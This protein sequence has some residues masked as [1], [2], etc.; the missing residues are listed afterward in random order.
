MAD[1]IMPLRAPRPARQAQRKLQ[2]DGQL[3]RATASYSTPTPERRAKGEESWAVDERP[4]G[5]KT[6]RAL[7]AYQ[8][9]EKHFNDRERAAVLRFIQ[10]MELAGRIRIVSSRTYNGMPYNGPGSGSYL[11]SQAQQAAA[12]RVDWILEHMD[13]RWLAFLAIVVLGVQ[14][15]RQGRPLSLDRLGAM[16]SAYKDADQR[17]ACAVGFA[18]GTFL[19]LDEAYAA[20]EVERRRRN[21]ERERRRVEDMT[22][23]ADVALA[24]VQREWNAE[25]ELLLRAY[26][27][28]VL[29]QRDAADRAVSSSTASNGSL[30]DGGD[31]GRF[32]DC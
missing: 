5:L 18:K 4:G 15:E 24:E 20:W 32:D 17:R 3:G 10:D 25:R 11:R 22:A 7:T 2:K 21:K 1:P 27:R 29:G 9:N 26:R 31:A 30:T 8:A 23:K 12:E 13:R 28:D 14:Y 19:R 6:Y 16:L